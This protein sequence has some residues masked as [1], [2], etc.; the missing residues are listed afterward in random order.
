VGFGKLQKKYKIQ[1]YQKNAV[2]ASYPKC[3]RT[4]LRM[5]MAHIL[6]QKGGDL[7]RQE[8]ILSLHWGP[9]NVI[10][11]FD[12]SLSIVLLIRDPRDVVVSYYHGGY[13]DQKLSKF[14]RG[15][16]GIGQCVK[17]LNRWA[18][19]FPKFKEVLVVGYEDLKAD[20]DVWVT[21]MLRLLKVKA[22]PGMVRKAVEFS[23]FKNM[24]TIER[25]RGKD[26]LLR[27]Y[28]GKFGDLRGS[29]RVRKGK[30]GGFRQELSPEDI[31]YVDEQCK[32]LHEAYSRYWKV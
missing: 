20:P 21:K 12:S 24:R 16:R 7:K 19:Y 14:I 6:Q 8:M 31:A 9:H 3:G 26:N 30:V 28:K 11:R 2:L 22:S 5:I 23:S 29:V 4:W 15:R 25:G 1:Y 10:R 18:R 32:A 17:Y 13:T 27:S